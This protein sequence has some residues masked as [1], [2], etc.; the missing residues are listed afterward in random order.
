[1]QKENLREE[2]KV[3]I[4]IYLKVNIIMSFHCLFY[5]FFMNFICKKFDFP[6]SR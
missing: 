1:M 6:Q 4:I 2:F 5:K 3:F